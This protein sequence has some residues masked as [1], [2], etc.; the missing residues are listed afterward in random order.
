MKP[1]KVDA[2]FIKKLLEKALKKRYGVTLDQFLAAKEN[3]VEEVMYPGSE[4]I[5][6][7]TKH[8]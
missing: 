5:S 3:G 7:L 1:F 2:K 4:D 6:E 8:L